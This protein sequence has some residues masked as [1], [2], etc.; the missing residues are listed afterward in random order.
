MWRLFFVLALAACSD[1]SDPAAPDPDC[2]G[3][4]YAAG[5]AKSGAAHRATLTLLGADPAPPAKGNN[6]WQLELRDSFALAVDEAAITVRPYMPHHGHGTGITAAITPSPG[7]RY[8]V[9]P[10]NLWMPGLWEITFDVTLPTDET[11]RVV[12]AFCIEG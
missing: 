10:L 5:L 4:T 9:A 12:F 3:D 6:A 2:V 7:G 1:E 8:D 11:D